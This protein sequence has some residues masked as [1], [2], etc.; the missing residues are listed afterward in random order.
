MKIVD[1]SHEITDGMSVFPDDPEC[2]VETA[3]NYENGYFVSK[4]TMNTHT[5]THLDAPAHKIKGGR[6]VTDFDLDAFC[7]E[8]AFALDC[9]GLSG[10]VDAAFLKAHEDQIKGCRAVLLC[11]GWSSKWGND[12]FFEGFPGL[13][14]DAAKALKEMGVRMI[15]LE[16]PAVNPERHTS[17]HQALLGEEIIVVEA[18]CG[19]EALLG[20]PFSFFAAPLWLTGRDGSP[21]R[22]FAIL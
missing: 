2:A 19:V 16:S 8:R 5:G 10:E 13:N 20:K 18:L 17:V 4:L 9:R 1:L 21:V 11:S 22:A 3:H 12:A 7:A 14:E 6:S 15:G